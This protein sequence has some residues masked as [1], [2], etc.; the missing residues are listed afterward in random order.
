[1]LSQKTPKVLFSMFLE[2][3]QMWFFKLIIKNND[4][5]AMDQNHMTQLWKY[6]AFSQV[7][8]NKI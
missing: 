8:A 3:L 7:I 5:S 4:A 6:L 2:I 1:L